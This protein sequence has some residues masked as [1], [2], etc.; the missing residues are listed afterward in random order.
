[1]NVFPNYILRETEAA[2]PRSHHHI[3]CLDFSLNQGKYEISLAVPE[4]MKF[5][6]NMSKD[7]VTDLKGLPRTK[8][9][10]IGT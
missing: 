6:K 3:H 1:M 10:K 4:R 5:S 9:G 2:S 8:S 7:M